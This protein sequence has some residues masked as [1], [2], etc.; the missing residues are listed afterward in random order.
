[1]D[2]KN[3][4]SVLTTFI[5]QVWNNGDFTEIENFITKQV[6]NNGDFTEIENFITPEY[7]IKNDPGDPWDG[8]ILR[9]EKYKARVLYSRDAFPDL[10]FEIRDMIEENGKVVLSWMASGTHD[11]DLPQLPATGKR[12]SVSGLTIYYFEGSKICGHTQSFDRLGFL[13]QIGF[14]GLDDIV[15]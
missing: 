12:F 14:L 6:W 8:Q 15:K 1:M 10:R 7:E 3:L 2:E 4:K 5:K 13:S 11:G 9:I